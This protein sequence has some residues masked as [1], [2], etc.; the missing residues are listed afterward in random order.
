VATARDIIQDSLERLGVYAPGETMGD[1]DAERGLTVLN[2]MLDSWSNESLTTFE[3]LEQTGALQ[4]G[5]SSY[6]I[7]AGGVFNTT[8]PIRILDGPGAAYIVDSSQNRYPLN[9]VPKA[10]WNQ[11]GL[12]TVTSNI[13]DTLYYDNAY[14]LGIINIFPVPL[15]SYSIYFDSYLQLVDFANLSTAVSLPPGYIKAMKD[16]LAVELWPY[17]KPDGSDPSAVLIEAASKS[18]ANVKRANLRENVAQYDQ[19]IVSRATPTYNIYRD[20]GA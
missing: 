11:I 15:I 6:T 4:V 7:G 8:R 9:V 19:E 1:A 12:L 13:P 16:V 10:Y 3:I 18:K 5:V 2:D 17:F 14:P 20:S